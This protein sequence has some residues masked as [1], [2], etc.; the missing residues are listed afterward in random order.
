MHIRDKKKLGYCILRRK[1]FSTLNIF[2]ETFSWYGRINRETSWDCKF[3]LVANTRTSCM[4]NGNRR[5]L[6]SRHESGRLTTSWL[7][8]DSGVTR[9]W[10]LPCATPF[11]GGEGLGFSSIIRFISAFLAYFVECRCSTVS[12]V[13]L[14]IIL[15]LN[16]KKRRIRLILYAELR[17]V[18]IFLVLSPRFDPRY[19]RHK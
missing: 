2:S 5:C 10:L 8:S 17:G 14:Q 16:C 6:I 12:F 13:R 18:L 9:V 3:K 4:E 7:T 1:E 19:F 15:I 11:L